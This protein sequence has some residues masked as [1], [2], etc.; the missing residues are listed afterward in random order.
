LPVDISI[1]SDDGLLWVNTF[2]DGTTRLFDISD[3]HKPVLQF[4]E[5]I[6]QQVNMV[7]QSWDGER[8]YFTTSLLA[9]WDKKGDADDQFLKLYK[10][11]G[12]KLDPVFSIDFKKE[13]L[14]RPHQMR[15]GAYAL[16]GAKPAEPSDSR[17]AVRD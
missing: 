12:K 5:V 13:K 9:N 10:W 2:L 11:D 16:Y 7:S 14:G 4:E 17:V 15:F 1:A 8:V 6:G 3:P